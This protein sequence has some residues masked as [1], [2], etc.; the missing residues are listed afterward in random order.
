VIGDRVLF[1]G[2]TGDNIAETML[3]LSQMPGFAAIAIPLAAANQATPL[4]AKIIDKTSF[5]Q[6]DRGSFWRC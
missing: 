1:G 5:S 4:E 6:F 3:L 2:S